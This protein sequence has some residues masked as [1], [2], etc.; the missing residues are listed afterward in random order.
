MDGKSKGSIGGSALKTLR[1]R[2][3]DIEMS[4]PGDADRDRKRNT[5]S[6]VDVPTGALTPVH[7]ATMT[8]STGSIAPEALIGGQQVG[9]GIVLKD[10]DLVSAGIHGGGG[11]GYTYR[12][13]QTQKQSALGQE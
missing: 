8:M 4:S 13:R 1:S 3:G 11:G 9:E 12:R 10:G 2:G 7:W 6:T 5:G